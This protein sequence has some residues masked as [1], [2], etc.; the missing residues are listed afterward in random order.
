MFYGT[1]MHTFQMS[2]CFQ[3][4]SGKILSASAKL[5]YG[6]YSING[7]L[8]ELNR[9]TFNACLSTIKEL[10]ECGFPTNTC[11]LY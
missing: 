1:S 7:A 9:Q 4:D 6:F 5:E 2:S 8:Q 10:V 11:G 3:H